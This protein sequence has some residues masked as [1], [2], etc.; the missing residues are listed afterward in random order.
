[1]NDVAVGG[2]RVSTVTLWVN[3]FIPHYIADLT[4]PYPKDPEMTML[5]GPSAVNDC[6]LTDQRSF[7]SN[8][9]AK[10]RVH[11]EVQVDLTG[12]PSIP[13]EHHACSQ[14]TEVDCEDGDVECSRT[15]VVRGNKFHNL[16][17]STSGTVTRVELD[18]QTEASNPCFNGS[19]DIDIEGHIVLSISPIGDRVSVHFD[20]YVDQ[21]PAFE[22]YATAGEGRYARSVF[23]V[24]PYPGKTPA[25]L[26][27]PADR[28]VS[29]SVQL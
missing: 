22:M 15:G 28:S 9:M 29:G 18:L 27:G 21:F 20:G 10:S 24:L 11:S 13:F 3:A 23:Q 1:M 5:P 14:T 16:S 25:D 12:E 7:S 26:F 8:I 6:F 19:P 17:V 2:N 4:K